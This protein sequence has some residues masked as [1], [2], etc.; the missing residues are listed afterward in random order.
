MRQCDTIIAN[1]GGAD[2]I[3]VKA[4]SVLIRSINICYGMI[5]DVE[6]EELEQ[7]IKSLER[8]EEKLGSR[9]KEET[10]GYYIEE[11]PIAIGNI[12][13]YSFYHSIIGRV[14]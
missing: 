9:E 6:V 10:R 5:V 14:L 8:K 11:A 2:E 1:P 3:Q 7:E 13:I 4:M 12:T